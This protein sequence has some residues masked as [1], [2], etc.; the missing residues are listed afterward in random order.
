[1]DPKGKSRVSSSGADIAERLERLDISDSRA[2][3]ASILLL[4]HLA[5]SGSYQA[6]HNTFIELT[7]PIPQR[8]RHPFSDTPTSAIH[9]T[10][11]FISPSKLAYAVKA[12]RVLAEGRF[13]PLAYFRLVGD[14][15]S[16]GPYER[17]VL[18]W[19]GDRVRE[20]AWKIMSKAYLGCTVEWGARWCGRDVSSTEEWVK[21]NGGR[22]ENGLIKM[23]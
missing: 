4:F 21:G 16:A 2:E 5:H 12:S 23:R 7:C 3:F 17:A 11:P 10:I 9:S 8:L 22:I 15:K 1:M 20:K 14:F 18:S 19:A 6:F 13:D